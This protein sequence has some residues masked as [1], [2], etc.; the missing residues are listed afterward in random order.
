L[1]SFTHIPVDVEVAKVYRAGAIRNWML[2]YFRFPEVP[3]VISPA[4]HAKIEESCAA[5]FRIIAKVADEVIAGS[6]ELD[7]RPL[8]DFLD[9]PNHIFYWL[10]EYHQPGRPLFWGRPDFH[11]RGGAP[12]L[13]EANFASAAG[14]QQQVTGL[15]HYY[16]SH[17]EY[18]DYFEDEVYSILSPMQGLA[19]AF[20]R[21]VKPGELVL[22]PDIQE[23]FRHNDATVTPYGGLI[24]WFNLHTGLRFVSGFIHQ[25]S[26]RPD[27]I[28]FHGQKV[29]HVFMSYYNPHVFDR[30]DEFLPI[31]D[32]FRKGRVNIVDSMNEV[33]WSNKLLMAFI[34][35][36]LEDLDLAAH[37]I[38]VWR[39]TVPWTRILRPGKS[40]YNGQLVD[41]EQFARREKDR[42]VLKK[43][44]SAEGKMVFVGRFVPQESWDE[45]IASVVGDGTWIIQEFIEPDAASLM[46]P[47]EDEY[48]DLHALQTIS[49]FLADNKVVGYLNRFY[50]IDPKIERTN[51]ACVTK[52]N[53]V[54][55]TV[56]EGGLP[57]A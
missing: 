23:D 16:T 9:I 11:I 18:L 21:T 4:T 28:W 22:I 36:Q 20:A 42:L 47:E 17:P 55:T 30:F 40:K 41:L 53:P 51:A 54:G 35:E 3:E 5:V 57:L 44:Q 50:A 48:R 10:R 27:G 2:S 12:Y 45:T 49:P 33:L 13:L 14:Y 25:L 26:F 52:L 31:W 6:I 56:I 19:A 37:D 38:A 7:G 15:H 24:S 29:D 39:E 1:G 34:D 43:A 46:V 32:L 8:A